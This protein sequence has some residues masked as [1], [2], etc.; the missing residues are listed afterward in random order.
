MAVTAVCN[1]K[2]ILNF[3]AF[4]AP[5]MSANESDQELLYLVGPG[6][7]PFT[8]SMLFNETS[9]PFFYSSNGVQL[10]RKQS[11]I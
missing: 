2:N 1:Q 3:L 11:R 7:H 10:D 8:C 5:Q 4:I 6:T 9:I